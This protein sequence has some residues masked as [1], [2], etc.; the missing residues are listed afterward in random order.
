[1]KRF[2]LVIGGCTELYFLTFGA[3]HG[4]HGDYA[5]GAWCLAAATYISAFAISLRQINAGYRLIGPARK[6]EEAA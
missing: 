5:R 3:W 1:M 4:M 6:H 2:L